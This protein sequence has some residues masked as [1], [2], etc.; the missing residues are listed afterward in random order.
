[1]TVRQNII[2]EDGH[3]YRLIA[4]H[5][6]PLYILDAEGT[7]VWYCDSGDEWPDDEAL[8]RVFLSICDMSNTTVHE[9]YGEESEAVFV[10]LKNTRGIMLPRP[11][12]IIQPSGPHPHNWLLTYIPATGEAALPSAHSCKANAVATARAAVDA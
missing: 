2:G 12:A 5:G 6:S 3:E 10:V 11:M 8:R 4:R 9:V 7:E 1:M